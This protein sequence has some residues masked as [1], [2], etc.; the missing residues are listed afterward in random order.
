M[1]IPSSPLALLLLGSE[2]HC[3]HV[4]VLGLG[5][6]LPV[7]SAVALL[8]LD[9]H[10]ERDPTVPSEVEHLDGM[11][12]WL[13]ILALSILTLCQKSP[14]PVSAAGKQIQ[15]AFKKTVKITALGP[16]PKSPKSKQAIS[17]SAL[18]LH[19]SNIV[20]WSFILKTPVRCPVVRHIPGGLRQD[21]NLSHLTKYPQ[22]RSQQ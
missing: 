5:K 20:F 7:H 9:L 22:S 2:S 4:L 10:R 21:L 6:A 16:A 14:S 13:L 3:W 18:N 15:A 11:Q 8:L 12:Y 1:L 19:V 17:T